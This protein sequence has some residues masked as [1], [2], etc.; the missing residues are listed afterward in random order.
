LGRNRNLKIQLHLIF[1]MAEKEKSDTSER[2]KVS[3]S[4][5]KDYL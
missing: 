1:G 5:E 4:I 3:V 2:K